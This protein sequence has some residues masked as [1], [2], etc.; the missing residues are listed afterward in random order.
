M[1]DWRQYCGGILEVGQGSGAVGRDPGWL[2]ERT[3]HGFQSRGFRGHSRCGRWIEGRCR[4][5]G[6]ASVLRWKEWRCLLV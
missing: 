2:P 4:V 5:A 3:G 6:G 1:G